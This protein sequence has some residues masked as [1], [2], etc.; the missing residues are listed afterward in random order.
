MLKKA[1][2]YGYHLLKKPITVN[3]GI[4]ITEIYIDPY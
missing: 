1:V 2:D 4:S 3:E